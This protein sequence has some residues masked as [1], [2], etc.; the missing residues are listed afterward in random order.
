MT[1]FHDNVSN[2][3]RHKPDKKPE[4]EPPID[5]EER[6]DELDDEPVGH[7]GLLRPQ[8]REAIEQLDKVLN[9]SLF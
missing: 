9:K 1:S 8:D 7:A 6:S 4:L 5:I 2:I 3:S